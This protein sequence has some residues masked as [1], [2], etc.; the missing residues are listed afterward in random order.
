M[1]KFKNKNTIYL[2]II[3]LFTYCP[4]LYA[5]NQEIIYTKEY[6]KAFSDMYA[7]PTDLEKTFKFAEQALL[8]GDFEG[9]VSA[10]ERMLL[11]NPNLPKIRLELGKL[12]M[13]LNSF[14]VAGVFF[15]DVVKSV[16]ASN[17]LKAEAAR[18]LQQTK[19]LQ[20]SLK[21]NHIIIFGGR[22]QSNANSAP[23]DNSI[24]LFG[25]PATL[26]ENFTS[27]EDLDISITGISDFKLESEYLDWLNYSGTFIFY[28]NEQLEQTNLNTKLL[29]INFGLKIDIDEFYLPLKINP[30]TTF[31]YLNLSDDELFYNYGFGFNIDTTLKEVFGISIKVDRKLMR[32]NDL[33]RTGSETSL[34]G[35]QLMIATD[36]SYSL[37]ST[38][39]MK[40]SLS[41][42][43]EDTK[44]K[45]DSSVT[46][47]VG[48]NYEMS[49]KEKGLEF[50]DKCNCLE[51]IRLVFDFS[52]TEKSYQAI[53]FST[54]ISRKRKD[55]GFVGGFGLK[56][57]INEEFTVSTKF[58]RAENRSNINNFDYENNTLSFEVT[59]LF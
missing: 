7:D 12:Y 39:L 53:D 58:Q 46:Q 1:K 25:V 57:Q 45:K 47:K 37:N 51:D 10:L 32:F 8:T 41:R 17:Q 35:D 38:D 9:A 54:D 2:F 55:Y 31:G 24:I 43:E 16:S 22:Y 15:N 18:L 44:D 52:I 29:D 5:S 13:R 3:S 48:L 23:E 4:N 40:L 33:S 49:P 36:L 14:S 19:N 59:Y 30:Y 34:N 28:G 6:E 42:L 56:Y 27:Q 20:S 26:E 50:L 21:I 11:I